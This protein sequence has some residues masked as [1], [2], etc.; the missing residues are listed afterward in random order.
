MNTAQQTFNHLPT[1]G[2]VGKSTTPL[3]VKYTTHLP[4]EWVKWVKREAVEREVKDYEVVM[5]ALDAFRR[6]RQPLIFLEN[7]S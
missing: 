5:M 3:V 2:E 7:G 1:S 4:K 6:S